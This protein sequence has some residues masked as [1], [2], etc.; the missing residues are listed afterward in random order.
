MSGSKAK[1]GKLSKTQ[2]RRLN[3]R[4]KSEANK[5]NKQS[6][7]IPTNTYIPI[8][9]NPCLKNIISAKS[10]NKG[11]LAEE[12]MLQYMKNWIPDIVSVADIPNSCDFW[13]ESLKLRV[14]LKCI[15][16]AEKGVWKSCICQFNRDAYVHAHDT[17]LFV[18]MNVGFDDSVIKTHIED[19]PTRLFI[20]G[21][22]MNDHMMDFIVE[23]ATSIGKIVYTCNKKVNIRLGNPRYV[24]STGDNISPTEDMY[25]NLNIPSHSDDEICY[26]YGNPCYQTTNNCYQQVNN[27]YQSSDMC[28]QQYNSWPQ[29]VDMCYQ[30]DNQCYQPVNNGYNYGNNCYQQTNTYYQT[31]NTSYQSSDVC[32]QPVNNCYTPSNTSYQPVSMISVSTDTSSD[33]SSP[34]APKMVHTIT[35]T[36]PSNSTNPYDLLGSVSAY[37]TKMS[38]WLN[39]II[40][41]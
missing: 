41:Q 1:N 19:N 34:S 26:N 27:S 18:F 31:V 8:R 6:K 15:S 36:D 22:D 12:Y 29:P 17:H 35:V 38:T 33:D 24:T 32:Y 7:P 40:S 21:K 13:S 3:K 2:R 30:Q 28:Y 5:Q 39:W 16:Q 25:S 10:G 11:Q 4:L 9:E 23:T 14:E 37:L 20:S